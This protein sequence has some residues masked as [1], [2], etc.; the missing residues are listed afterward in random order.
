MSSNQWNN[1][2][3]AE[4]IDPGLPEY[5]DN[6]FISALPKI[7]SFA[8][9]RNELLLMPE[10]SEAEL[11]LEKSIRIH[12]IQRLISK[13]FLPFNNH[14]ILEAKFSMLIRQ[15]YIGRNPYNGD[16]TR[17]LNAGY[18]RVQAG[19]INKQPEQKVNSTARSFAIVGTS[20]C[21]KSLAIDRILYSYKKAI[22]HPKLQIT[23]VP[24]IK[25]E[26]P[27]KGSLG[28]LCRRL[29]APIEN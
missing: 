19:D 21:G 3:I 29:L 6:P 9:A 11:Q 13:F 23:Q 8:E 26:C 5:A 1:I 20:G 2:E 12:A 22:F 28:E 17:H 27:H 25:L 16:L 4:Y 10:I 7:K 14:L 15:G 18:E 24:W